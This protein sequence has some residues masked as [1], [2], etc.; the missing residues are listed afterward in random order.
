M[1]KLV[2]TTYRGEWPAGVYWSPGEVREVPTAEGAP[3]GVEP[4]V[5]P[6]A[7]PGKLATAPGKLK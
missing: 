6:K 7:S 2:S 4:V 3:V 5:E 1:V